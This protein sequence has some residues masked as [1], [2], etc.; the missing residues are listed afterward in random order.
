MNIIWITLESLLPPNSGGRLGVYKRLEQVAK[1][2]RVF[3]FYPYDDDKE[4]KYAEELEKYCEEVHAYSRKKNRKSAIKNLMRYPYTVSSRCIEAMKEDIR[5]C[6]HQNHIDLINVDFPHM[7]VDLLDLNIDIPVILNEHNIEWKVYR[8]IAKSK[9]NLIK[10]VIYYFDSIRLKRYEL[11]IAK[12]IDFSRITY[13]STD[14]MREM[15]REGVYK[16]EKTVLIPVG[17][18]VRK[19]LEKNEDGGINILFVGKMSYGPNIEAVKWFAKEIFPIILKSFPNAVFY[20]VG[21]EPTA[22]V[23]RLSDNNIIVTGMVDSVE[24]FYDKSSLVVLPLKNGGGVKVKLLEAISYNVP[25]VSTSVGVEGT[26]FSDGKTIPVID[27][28]EGFANACIC[29]LRGTYKD[30]YEKMY[31]LFL[32][33]YTWESIGE[34]YIRM[35]RSVI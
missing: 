25:V 19:S 2:E 30:N 11:K 27:E 8:N 4:I 33:Q 14:D 21:K 12:R 29:A 10:K 26:L 28:K 9:K 1:T 16:E 31:K 32:D 13:V 34:K 5:L 23:T 20:I 6:L 17:A 15:V 22:E 24:E 3:L 18:D 35:L 7:C